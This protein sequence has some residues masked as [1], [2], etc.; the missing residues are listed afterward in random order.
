MNEDE[1]RMGYSDAIKRY[2]NI[3][4]DREERRRIRKKEKVD[5]F[6]NLLI[7]KIMALVSFVLAYYLMAFGDDEYGAWLMFAMFGLYLLFTRKQV[8]KD[9]K[10]YEYHG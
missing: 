4:E 8:F 7:Q 6:V 2:H 1:Y 5:R 10:E 3:M 9:W